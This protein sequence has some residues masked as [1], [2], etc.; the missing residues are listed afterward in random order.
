MSV[1][2]TKVAPSPFSLAG[3]KAA[4]GGVRSAAGRGVFE[5]DEDEEDDMGKQKVELR[6]SSVSLEQVCVYHLRID[7]VCSCFLGSPNRYAKRV[8]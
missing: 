6:E 2:G 3:G 1:F 4:F 8:A 7:D 5:D